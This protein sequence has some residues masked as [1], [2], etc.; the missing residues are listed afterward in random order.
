[1]QKLDPKKAVEFYEAT[2]A[3]AENGDADAQNDIGHSYWSG[4]GAPKDIREAIKWFTKAA[5]Q[6]HPVAQ[7]N[8]GFNH[9]HVSE[10]LRDPVIAYKWYTICFKNSADIS[11]KAITAEA[12]SS[13][14]ILSKKMTAEQI[15]K[16]EALAEEMIK[17][18]P[19]LIKADTP[20]LLATPKK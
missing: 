17:K 3:R 16:A 18:N 6:G 11:Y 2:L 20:K 5:E 10:N 14:D 7:Y 4:N 12:K 9:D 8:V 15:A 19:K 13:R 1:M